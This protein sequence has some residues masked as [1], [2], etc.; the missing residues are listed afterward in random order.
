MSEE[1]PKYIRKLE[2]D[3]DNLR[4][5]T[6]ERI[7]FLGERIG[8]TL[9]LLYRIFCAVVNFMS[10]TMP[11]TKETVIAEYRFLREFYQIFMEWSPEEKIRSEFNT[12][13]KDQLT[14]I[15]RGA[16][17]ITFDDMIDVLLRGLGRDLTRKLVSPD[18]IAEVWGA[19]ALERFKEMLFE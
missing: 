12:S 13:F 15:L 2:E 11:R 9:W 18:T 14:K 10:S 5:E 6:N 1:A 4:R 7:E 17:V 8:S 16:G 3:I 19:K